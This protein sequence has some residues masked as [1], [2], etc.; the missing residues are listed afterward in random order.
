MTDRA[1]RSRRNL[2]GPTSWRVT[3]SENKIVGLYVACTA[4]DTVVTASNNW[5]YL[6][7][8]QTSSRFGLFFV[9]FSCYCISVQS[10]PGLA[11]L[12]QEFRIDGRSN[13]NRQPAAPLCRAVT[14]VACSK[15]RRGRE[16]VSA[17][18]RSGEFEGKDWAERI[19]SSG[20]ERRTK[21]TK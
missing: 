6:D 5:D 7:D 19:R 4:L 18:R 12:F 10:K 16:T 8:F 9:L 21:E 1:I 3:N 13:L 11:S 14:L 20:A 2:R 17:R 15:W